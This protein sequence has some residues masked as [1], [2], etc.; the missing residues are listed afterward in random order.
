MATVTEDDEVDPE[1]PLEDQDS[2]VAVEFAALVEKELGIRLEVDDLLA[3][4][5]LMDLAELVNE[6][7]A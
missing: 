3:C 5:N 1:S 2:L 4:E 7:I 6:R